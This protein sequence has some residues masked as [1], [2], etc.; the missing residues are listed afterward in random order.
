MT[1]KVLL[2][3]GRVP[4]RSEYQVGCSPRAHPPCTHWWQWPAQWWRQL[5]EK[6]SDASRREASRSGIR[7]SPAQ[8]HLQGLSSKQPLS[9]ELLSQSSFHISH[10]RGYA[11]VPCHSQ[12]CSAQQLNFD[13]VPDTRRENVSLIKR[14]AANLTLMSS[15]NSQTQFFVLHSS[16]SYNPKSQASSGNSK[17]Q[18][19]WLC[20]PSALNFLH[21]LSLF[22]I[23]KVLLFFFFW[24]TFQIVI[25]FLEERILRSHKCMYM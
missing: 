16:I 22:V 5:L 4:K 18:N 2:A 23:Q 17:W 7:I 11:A 24:V 12:Q 21:P 10:G 19:A 6:H 20:G 1:I 14:I 3:Q 8:A 15:L 13:K 25:R 9:P